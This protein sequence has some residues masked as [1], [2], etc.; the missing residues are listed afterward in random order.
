MSAEKSMNVSRE[1]SVQQINSFTLSEKTTRYLAVKR[2][3]DI[4]FALIGLAIARQ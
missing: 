4:W 1:F 2:V 3:M